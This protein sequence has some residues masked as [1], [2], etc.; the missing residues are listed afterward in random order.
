LK[1]IRV[2]YEKQGIV[3]YI[4]HLDTVRCMD[5]VLRRSKLPVWYTEG[6][7]PHIYTT[8][9]N[10]LSLGHESL[11]EIMEF[12]LEQDLPMDEIKDRLN[13][14]MPDGFH[15]NK[16]EEAVR[17]FADIAAATYEISL[18]I[19]KE[20]TDKLIA[21]LEKDSIITLKK[22]KKGMKEADIKPML[23]SYEMKDGILHLMVATGQNGGLNPALLLGA[24]KEQTDSVF[25]VKRYLRTS[26]R[27][28]DFK[29]FS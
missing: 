13:G 29:L 16:A 17:S 18:D 4:S 11:C 22:S 27:D 23:F 8:F 14:A 25:E 7:N 20:N 19:D 6:F 21:F 9:A 28:K 5:R 1:T 15:V 2:W 12:R 10:P 3:K 26:L 24:C